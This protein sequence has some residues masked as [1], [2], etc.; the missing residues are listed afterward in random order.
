LLTT[1]VSEQNMEVTFDVETST[2]RCEG[3]TLMGSRKTN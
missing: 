3:R 1:E 2:S